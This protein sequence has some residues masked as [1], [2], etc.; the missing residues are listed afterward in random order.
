MLVVTSSQT[1]TVE[2]T[3]SPVSELDWVATYID[4]TDDNVSSTDGV[5]NGTTPV[6]VVGSPAA[7]Q[8]MVRQMQFYQSDAVIRTII[9]KLGTRVLVQRA[10]NPGDTLVYDSQAG[11]YIA[12]DTGIITMDH[13]ALTN[14]DYASAGHTGFEPTLPLSTRGDVLVRNAANITA[15]LPIGSADQVLG[16]DGTD[17]AWVDPAGGIDTYDTVAAA[18]AVGGSNYDLIYCVETKTLYQYLAAGGAY[19]DDNTFVLSTG[20][21]VDT[22]WIGVSGQYIAGNL[23]VSSLSASQHVSTNVNKQLVSQ[24]SAQVAAAIQSSINHAALTNRDYASAGHTGFEPTLPLST[25]GDV[26]FRDSSNNTARLALGSSGQVLSSNGTDLVW[27]ASTGGGGLTTYDTIALAEAASGS[28]NDLCFVVETETIYRYESSAATATDNNTS[29][30]S[31]GD[32][33]N[34]RWL[35][36]GGKYIFNAEQLNILYIGKHGDD[37]NNGKT[38]ASAFLTFAAAIAAAVA[39]TPS[40]SNRVAIQCLDSGIYTED[41]SVPSYVLVNAPNASLQGVV[42][43]LTISEFVV[44]VFDQ[45]LVPTGGTGIS[46]TGSGGSRVE[47]TLLQ[48]SGTGNGITTSGGVLAIYIRAL[49]IGTGTGITGTA[50][51]SVIGIVGQTTV[52]GAGTMISANNNCRIELT[53]AGITDLGSTGTGVQVGSGN[54][55]TVTIGTLDFDSGGTAINVATTGVLNIVP[56]DIDGTVT[57]FGAIQIAGGVFTSGV[58]AEIGSADHWVNGVYYY[59]YDIMTLFQWNG[60]VWA[61]MVSYGPVTLYADAINGSDTIG[62]GYAPGTSAFQTLGYAVSSIP[63]INGGDVLVEMAGGERINPANTSFA[64]NGANIE[65]TNT[66]DSPF[67]AALDGKYVS[68]SK[69]TTGAND[70][71]YQVTYVSATQIDIVNTGATEAAGANTEIVCGVYRENPVIQGK[72]FSASAEL[73]IRGEVSDIESST[74]TGSSGGASYK[75][76][77][78]DDTSVSW[79]TDQHKGK[80]VS[81]SAAPGQYRVIADNTGTRLNLV[82][83]FSPTPGIGTAYTIHGWDTILNPQSNTV[84]VQGAQQNM[85]FELIDF[86]TL[87]TSGTAG[88]IKSQQYAKLE[89]WYCRLWNERTTYCLIANE[90]A[91][92]KFNYCF[93]DGL[94]YGLK[95]NSSNQFRVNSCLVKGYKQVGGV[96][97]GRS[98]VWVNGTYGLVDWGTIIEDFETCYAG[99][100]G[101]VMDLSYM[102][103]RHTGVGAFGRGVYAVNASENY[104]DAATGGRVTFTNLS[105]NWNESIVV[106]GGNLDVTGA[107]STSSTYSALL[108]DSSGNVNLRVDDD[109]GMHVPQMKSGASQA[110]AGAVAGEFWFDTSDGNTIKMGV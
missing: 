33:G 17:V 58:I 56:G 90:A 77:Y 80:L 99:E 2:L 65:I 97:P 39:Q 46:K 94:R 102:I 104:R 43:A 108:K 55:A 34:T 96:G 79:A 42:T 16:T 86:H 100:G 21:A 62:N 8:R 19:T 24:T 83:R 72:S 10:V 74:V 76:A 51:S 91:I 41:I 40:S 68:I 36:A 25:R 45:V 5:S 78:I 103:L 52:N 38:I 44:A 75:G 71:T 49:Y 18:E 105:A 4:E 28:D 11:W 50:T 48:C 37:G 14:R 7:D 88:I 85:F 60:S 32:G 101:A 95:A 106:S 35:G 59:A 53:I 89:L 31:T 98:G 26:L 1:I 57:N 54:M 47:T 12:F 92:C 29:V 23:F 73:R 63:A 3:D 13:A 61:P 81:C 82:G 6:V 70:G 20:D 87:T 9:V 84:I 69:A 30:L 107:T 27:A 110:L 67:Y 15:R 109:G 64:Q 93:V 22:R 66:V